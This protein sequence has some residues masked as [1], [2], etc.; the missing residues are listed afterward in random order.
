M[1]SWKTADNYDPEAFYTE[2]RDKN[3]GGEIVNA[4]IP[5]QIHGSLAALVQS[6]KIPQYRTQ[7]DF[8]RNA[9]VHQLHRDLERIQDQDQMRKL[10]MIILLNQEISAQRE[11]D[12]YNSLMQMV[13][14]RHLEYV[15]SGKTEDARLYIKTRLTEIDA[16]P[17]RY[18]D[19][20]EKRL[21]AKLY[22]V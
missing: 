21:G 9:M 2:A 15:L 13:E 20:Y 16:I 7:S 19:D 14:A 11:Q 5:P 1:T 18:Q 22:P 3:G 10:N 17:D 4:R 6:G 12:D 8:I